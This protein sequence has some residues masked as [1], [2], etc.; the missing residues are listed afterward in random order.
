M[1]TIRS[2]LL[3]RVVVMS[4]V[5][6][7]AVGIAARPALAVTLFTVNS[8]G[9]GG[10]SG[11]KD[12]A[13]NDGTGNCTLRAAIQQANGSAGT[14]TID[15]A[16]PVLPPPFTVTPVIKP[17]TPLPAVSGTA[18][19]DAST[20]TVT[21]H[22]ILDGSAI[23]GG[24]DGFQFTAAGCTV[25]GFTV[26][27]FPLGIGVYGNAP[28]LTVAGNVLGS[29]TG[30]GGNHY[31]VVSAG[32]GAIIGGTT[33]A[34]RNVISGNLA[35][36]IVDENSS[37]L[38]EG[39]YIGTTAAG[40][41]PAPNGNDGV[42]VYSSGTMIGPGNVI[43]GNTHN[44]VEFESSLAHDDTLT[45]NFIGTNPSGSA[46]VANQLSG[47]YVHADAHDI[48]VGGGNVVSGND[49]S[50]VVVV[51]S[52]SSGVSVHGNLIGTD[53]TGTASIA[54]ETGVYLID[55]SGTVVGG[56]TAADRNVI[57][58]NQT[59][60]VEIQQVSG[61]ATGNTVE[62]N[63][64]GTN[65]AGTGPVPNPVGALVL[66]ADG[67]TIG[68]PA[69]GAGNLISGNTTDGVDL[70]A[71]DTTL[72]GNMIGTNAT[73]SAAVP[74]NSSGVAV[75]GSLSEILGNVIS[76]NASEGVSLS[77]DLASD[78]TLMG[79]LIGT[80]ATGSAAVPNGN[81]IFVDAPNNQI[82]GGLPSARN[83]VSGNS[84]SGV[85]VAQSVSS[86]PPAG[87]QIEGNYVGL[88][89]SGSAPLGNALNGILVFDAGAND[90][91]GTGSA[92]GNVISANGRGVYV[93]ASGPGN[94][95]Y[96]NLIGTD[97]TGTT[98]GDFGND[99]PGIRVEDTA[100]TTIGGTKAT[101]R[102]VISGNQAEG[103]DLEGASGTQIL[104][105]YIGTDVT[106]T[107]DRGNLDDGILV[108]GSDKNTIGGA[109]AGDTNVISGNDGN[110]IH[111]DAKTSKSNKV[112]GN[113]IGTQKDGSSS[114]GN[115]LNGILVEGKAGKT[116][117]GG[118]TAKA[119]NVVANNGAAGVFVDSGTGNA[120]R[121]NAIYGNGSLGIDLHPAGV[122]ANDAGDPDKGANLG[123]NYPVVTSAV[124]SGGITTVV[125]TLNSTANATF[126]VDVFWGPIRDPSLFGEGQVFLGTLSVTTD[127]SG[128][129]TFSAPFAGTVPAGS[130][131]TATATD[132]KG[133]TSE[134]SQ[135]KKST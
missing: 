94:V 17:A 92:D 129:V 68:G 58:G 40:T 82:G 113:L 5:S 108:N 46:A 75:T 96:G 61:T 16:I 66:A 135:A 133:N 124:S 18:I 57:S 80:D 35:D 54:N 106:G 10:D 86:V 79:N 51:G 97:A 24:A 118:T 65:A 131:V 71:N 28:S 112:L 87:N 81:G 21:H 14:Q 60:G 99:G 56:T 102:N 37:D 38:I 2:S 59:D 107:L 100:G 53:G 50:G 49:G 72:Q 115:N 9:D 93:S 120:I 7:A 114:L 78:N 91:G 22:V 48:S 11:L 122:N 85:V 116:T 34:D 70:S 32:A 36:G 63:Y 88:A 104:G 73:G 103:I 132:A 15:F 12:N 69:A 110:A 67:N 76:G 98:T 19:I 41:A 33:A 77:G 23:S 20:Q 3:S 128:N 134:F 30:S 74:N 84:G 42:N 130:W 126:Q 121:E 26:Q 89:A 90:I 27:G 119:R 39:N 117:I 25:R 105:N 127:G 111:L 44:G 109:K 43:S 13:C 123:Q 45:G 6:F 4:L 52:T 95:V 125:G 8:T 55:V 64:I 101:T 31:G 47:V 62:G 29:V 83:V 1:R